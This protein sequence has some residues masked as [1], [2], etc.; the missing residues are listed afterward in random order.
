MPFN[1][2]IEEVDDTAPAELSGEVNLESIDLSNAPSWQVEISDETKSLPSVGGGI[3]NDL[4]L[5]KKI[6]GS[7]IEFKRVVILTLLGLF[8]I[9][10]LAVVVSNVTRNQLDFN[11]YMMVVGSFLAGLGIGTLRKDKELKPG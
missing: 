11:T 6:I 1:W 7:D 10:F 2:Q 4:S 9:G 5:P 3:V 8:G